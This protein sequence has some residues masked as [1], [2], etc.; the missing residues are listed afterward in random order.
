MHTY[1]TPQP[2]S[3]TFLERSAD[4][5]GAGR[6]GATNIATI[7]RKE[8]VHVVGVSV[9][10]LRLFEEPSRTWSP[11]KSVSI[12]AFQPNTDVP[13]SKQDSV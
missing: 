4:V 1:D 9:P 3:H 7:P 11:M 12:G 10:D 6:R 5:G 2:A 8:L 13:V